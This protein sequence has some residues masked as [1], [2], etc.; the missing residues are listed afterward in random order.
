[1]RIVIFILLCLVSF[2]AAAQDLTGIWRGHFK[3]I[4]KLYDSL[5]IDDRYKFE[6]HIEQNSKSFSGVTYSYRSTIFYGK[7]ACYGAINTK[8]KG[9]D[10]LLNSRH[11]YGKTIF[12]ISLAANFNSTRLFGAIQTSDKLATNPQSSNT[13]FN[14]EEI[15]KLEKGQ[16]GSKIILSVTCSTGK[17][18]L[19]IVNTRFGKTMIA[20]LVSP[21]E[22]FS[23]KI[24]TDISLH[25]SLKQW[26]TVILG[27][28]NV[29]NIYPDQ[30]KHRLNKAQG[31]WI[32]SP[33]ASPFGFN[34]GYYFINLVFNFQ[35]KN[36]KAVNK[37]D[38]RVIL[39]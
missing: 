28:N 33:E 36:K 2:V 19:N 29:A 22:T 38:D 1:M 11:N 8:T 20:P 5:G 6:T 39:R 15:T 18:K 7:A 3:S 35:S 34:G 9:I 21:A 23:P 26:A 17:I 14:A 16:P 4:N 24:L 25:Y 32:Y 13:L 31:R 12:E 10:I 27:A 37:I 30:L